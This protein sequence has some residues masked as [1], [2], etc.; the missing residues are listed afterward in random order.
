L[1]PNGNML[2]IIRLENK[3]CGTNLYALLHFHGWDFF[4]KLL[5]AY[6]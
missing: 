1:L 2:E 6:N 5:S 3:K 4:Q